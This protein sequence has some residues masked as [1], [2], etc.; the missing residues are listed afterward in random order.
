MLKSKLYSCCIFKL[1]KFCPFQ[2]FSN[3]SR[4]LKEM[5][6]KFSDVSIL[7]SFWLETYLYKDKFTSGAIATI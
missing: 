2:L 3:N 7:T 5:I 6:A 4:N 1:P